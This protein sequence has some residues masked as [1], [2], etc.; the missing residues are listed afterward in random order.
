VRPGQRVGKYVLGEQI[1][2]GGMAEVWAA[3]V[4]GPGGFVKSL[5]LKFI[6]ESFTGDADLERLFLNEARVAARLQH[7]NLVSVFDFDKVRDDDSGGVGRYY[8]AMERV[9]G[10]DL[11]RVLQVSRHRGQRMAPG[12]GLHIAA[13]VTRGLRYVHECRDDARRQPL[14]LVHRDVSP[15]NILVGMDGQVK[16]SDFG[17]AKAMTQS[18]GTQSGM[19]RGKLAYASPEQLRSEPVDH[20]ADQFGL[21]VTLWEMLSDRRLFDG[22]DE[23]QIVAKVL[24]CEIPSLPGD[25]ASNPAVEILARRMLAARACDRFPS[26]A[27]VLS[28]MVSTPGYVPDAAP[29]IELM[30]NL[31]ASQAI[32][33]PPTVPLTLSDPPPV[34]AAAVTRQIESGSPSR[35]L[36]PATLP[37]SVRPPPADLG[38][39]GSR[40]AAGAD[41]E[42]SAVSARDGIPTRIEPADTVSEATYVSG[43]PPPGGPTQVGQPRVSRRSSQLIWVF[44][45]ALAIAVGVT[46]AARRAHR[47]AGLAAGSAATP[48]AAIVPEGPGRPE[49]QTV[50][51]GASMARSPGLP[52]DESRTPAPNPAGEL[53]ERQLGRLGPAFEPA[54]QD[55]GLSAPPPPD[56][57][58][59]AGSRPSGKRPYHAADRSRAT[60]PVPAGEGGQ[61][62]VPVR[63]SRR[64]EPANGAP[65]LE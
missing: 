44:G 60:A 41:R 34:S 37:R 1:A 50:R 9:D 8:I 42:K 18:L 57:P 59:T 35:G 31:F 32:T 47:S 3:R 5:A 13:E 27:E 36:A 61:G 28:A 55:V 30:Q 15:H 6:L 20:R 64:L 21:G 10:Y 24:R 2:R 58:S 4:E 22:A 49:G 16:L 29:L 7:P 54:E 62:V 48:A 17:I 39:E 51:E 14:G 26:T 43:E 11:R 65:L 63:S 38:P 45:A 19:I 25:V 52:A 53:S 56:H 23:M 12:I 40:I 33:V 46:V